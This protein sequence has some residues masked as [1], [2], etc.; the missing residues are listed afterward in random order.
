VAVENVCPSST[1]LALKATHQLV[2]CIDLFRKSGTKVN[3]VGA[4]EGQ[5]AFVTLPSAIMLYESQDS[6]VGIVT[7]YGLDDRGVGVRVPV[8]PRIF[9]STCS[10][11]RIWGPP[12]GM[13]SISPGV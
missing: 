11:D 4:G 5:L 1:L 6:S 7:G 10:S 3:I 8:G 13:G 12:T 2:L 9:T